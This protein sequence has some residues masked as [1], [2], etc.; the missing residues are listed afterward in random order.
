MNK[1]YIKKIEALSESLFPKNKELSG[2]QKFQKNLI[3]EF[4]KKDATEEQY[5]Y[6]IESLKN[7][8]KREMEIRQQ[9][10]ERDENSN[11]NKKKLSDA[12]GY[13]VKFDASDIRQINQD[14]KALNQY[15]PSNKGNMNITQ[16]E[17]KAIIK[18]QKAQKSQK[19]KE[20]TYKDNVRK[21]IIYLDNHDPKYIT[22]INTLDHDEKQ[23]LQHKLVNEKRFKDLEKIKKSKNVK[24]LLKSEDKQPKRKG[25]LKKVSP[26][27]IIETN[28]FMK[29]KEKKKEKKAYIEEKKINKFGS[30]RNLFQAE[31]KLK[32]IAHFEISY[33]DEMSYEIEET[34]GI[35]DVNE[36]TNIQRLLKMKEEAFR[37]KHI[38]GKKNSTHYYSENIKRLLNFT[39]ILSPIKKRVKKQED[40]KMTNQNV[41][42]RDWLRYSKSIDKDSYNDMNNKC[43]YS[44]LVKFLKP[45]WTKVNEEKLIEFFKE[46]CKEYYEPAV[47]YDTE[48]ENYN[49]YK[50]PIY[51]GDAD[52]CYSDDEDENNEKSI[53]YENP[54]LKENVIPIKKYIP[55]EERGVSTRMIGELCLDKNIT[56]YAFNQDD[57]CFFN[58]RE[59]LIR[60]GKIPKNTA[61]PPLCFYSID[62][63][64]YLLNNDV[65]KSIGAS[66][67]EKKNVIIQSSALEFDIEKDEKD[68]FINEREMFE[69]IS[70]EEA[71]KLNDSIVFMKQSDLKEDIRAYIDKTKNL[72][73][74]KIEN[75]KIIRMEI[76]EKNLTIV[77]DNSNLMDHNQV[78]EICKKT[79]IPYKNQSVGTL[80]KNLENK[81]FQPARKQLTKEQKIELSKNGCNHC[82]LISLYYEYDH[83]IP[84]CVCGDN[85]ISNFQALCE[86]C[87]DI[88]TKREND[89]GLYFHQDNRM[90]SSFNKLGLDII[91]SYLSKHWAVVDNLQSKRNKGNKLYKIDHIGCRKNI[92]YYSK[93]EYP[94]Y[95]VM[96]DPKPYT[97]DDIK[98]G[99]YYIECNLYVSGIRGNGWYS[100][101]IINRCLEKNL[102]TRD[103]IKFEFI[104]SYTIPATQFKSFIDFIKK[105]CYEEDKKIIENN[106]KEGVKKPLL[107]KTCINSYI[108][109]QAIIKSEFHSVRFTKSDEEASE[110]MMHDNIFVSNW[111]INNDIMLYE[112]TETMKILNDEIYLPIY[113]Q[114]LAIEA[115]NLYDLEEFV[116][117][118]DGII[119]DRNTDSILYEGIELDISKF[120]WDDDKSVEKYRYEKPTLLKCK[121]V[122]DFYRR[123]R[124]TLPKIEY[125]N[126]NEI[127]ND[128]Y[129]ENLINEVYKSKKGCLIKA[130]SGCGKTEFMKRFILK[131]ENENKKIKKVAPSNKSARLISGETIHKFSNQLKASNF[132]QKKLIKDL[133]NVKYIFVDEYGMLT[134]E[135]YRLLLMIKRYVPN[136]CIIVAGD[137][138]QLAPVGDR[139]QG[140]YDTSALHYIVDG[141]KIE[142]KTCHRSDKRLFNLYTNLDNINIKEFKPK[143]KTHLNICYVHTTRKRINNELN[144]LYSKEKEVIKVEK[145]LKNKNTQD[146]VIYEGCPIVSF[147]NVRMIEKKKVW[148]CNSDDYKI[149][150][151]DVE[152][153]TFTITFI[154]ENDENEDLEISA[155][156]FSKMFLFG[157]ARTIHSLQGSSIE[158]NYTIFDWCHPGFEDRLKYVSLSRAHHFNQINIMP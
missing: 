135:F 47:V 119:I 89:N 65:Y 77:C 57:K 46:N 25:W 99:M 17:E 39:H 43:V 120:F 59:T 16:A 123:E 61:Y 27:D 141:N 13:E 3:T 67:K 130:L 145:S 2:Y 112:I 154:N 155:K 14:K 68:E 63:H 117:E 142:F 8:L 38:K 49:N 126:I 56:M 73:M 156:E 41:L 91:H 151:I 115:C 79:E 105:S 137:I 71:T 26:N 50:P 122:C 80:L 108:G 148:I 75:N 6:K 90:S 138:T 1:K 70:F 116:I 12:L 82:K 5:Q 84:L 98:C 60:A 121:S 152:K 101:I 64:M 132:K 76:K 102:I 157:Y 129:F 88:K 147:K 72:P 106:L 136:I 29:L 144:L 53:Y 37:N 69:N 86:E 66:Q 95:T 85:D 7:D 11:L 114:I 118:N 18:K 92:V 55:L 30:K 4:I 45:V 21:A 52:V 87:H 36:Y 31:K 24:R 140:D 107:S 125:N 28:F 153:Q 15:Y 103:I 34:V 150:K 93:E 149:K 48:R 83:I 124:Y 97:G 9:T 35:Y 54:K 58:N 109:M 133:E 111:K 113:N 146:G 32:L 23:E 110:K 42:R 33:K 96:D 128:V 104:P 22:F 74:L 20:F 94:Q 51:T 81:F 139:Y 78:L 40:I 100:H 131:L 19:V 134:S 158:E 10:R 44:L 62:N 127:E 143:E